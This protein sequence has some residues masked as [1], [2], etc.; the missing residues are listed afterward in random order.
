MGEDGG[1]WFTVPVV[2]VGWLSIKGKV[3]KAGG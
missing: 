3:S 2:R 1:R